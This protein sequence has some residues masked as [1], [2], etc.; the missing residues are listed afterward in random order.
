LGMLS[1]SLILE[2]S[3][4]PAR[5]KKTLIGTASRY[6]KRANEKK[7]PSVRSAIY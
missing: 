6:A 5:E 3:I 1:C 4:K 7:N 2:S